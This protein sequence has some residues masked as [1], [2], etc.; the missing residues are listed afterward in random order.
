[1]KSKDYQM[2]NWIHNIKRP[3]IF[4]NANDVFLMTILH[5]VMDKRVIFLPVSK[6]FTV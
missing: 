3:K 5:K 2:I 6:L 4:I 1:M